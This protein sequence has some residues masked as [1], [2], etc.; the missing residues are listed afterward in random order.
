M[1]T[2]TADKLAG[3]SLWDAVWADPNDALAKLA[4][5]DL[6][7]ETGAGGP[8]MALGL[9]EAAARGRH[10]VYERDHKV[11]DQP[12]LW[13]SPEVRY[14]GLPHP[15]ASLPPALYRAVSNVPYLPG[16]GFDLPWAF[17]RLGVALRLMR[18][19]G[20]DPWDAELKEAEVPW[21]VIKEALRAGRG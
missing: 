4:L 12:Y 11:M 6:C 1:G 9:R 16:R 18:S 3:A 17:E 13:S 10:P 19:S 21:G 14:N 15:T 2:S 20:L 7:E 5:A 8:D